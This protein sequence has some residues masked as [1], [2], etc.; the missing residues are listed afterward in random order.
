MRATLQ[1]ERACRG[2]STT[3]RGCDTWTQGVDFS[4]GARELRFNDAFRYLWWFVPV[5]CCR[6]AGLLSQ[7]HLV[8]LGDGAKLSA[9]SGAYMIRVLSVA[10]RV[11][12]G[13]WYNRMKYAFVGLRASDAPLVRDERLGFRSS[14][15]EQC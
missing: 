1:K 12:G 14:R 11:Y 4:G 10:Q 15:R 13:S 6:T 7:Q 2:M 8:V 9:R 5:Y 3:T